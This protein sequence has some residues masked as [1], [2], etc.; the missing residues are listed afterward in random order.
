M[1]SYIALLR[2]ERRSHYGVEFPDFPGCVTAGRTLDEARRA[3]EEALALHMAGMVEDGDEIPAPRALDAVLGGEDLRGAVPF[4][5]SVREPA[6]R[7]VRVNVTF[8]PAVLEALDAEAERTR[9]HALGTTRGGHPRAGGAPASD[10]PTRAREAEGRAT[11]EPRRARV[12][13]PT[14]APEDAGRTG[15]RGPAFSDHRRRLLR[16]KRPRGNSAR[17][18]RKRGARDGSRTR[19]PQL[20]NGQAPEEVTLSCGTD[21]AGGR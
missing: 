1:A 20:G 3:A 13:R 19:D 14:R 17:A 16:R 7:V 18:H 9:S 10:G 12:S 2:K 6:P 4:L 5:V 15:W 21:A 11:P 8:K